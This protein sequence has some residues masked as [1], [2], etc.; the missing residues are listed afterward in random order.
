M[1]KDTAF[2]A[3][4]A[5]LAAADLRKATAQIQRVVSKRVTIPVLGFVKVEMGPIGIRLTATDT[6]MWIEVSIDALTSMP[7][8]TRMISAERLAAF[9]RIATG[10]VTISFDGEM[11][12]LSDDATTIKLR[13]RI[14][15]EDFPLMS[16]G[17]RDVELAKETVMSAE[18][19]ARL[20]DLSCGYASNEETRYYL[21]G[22]HLCT[23]PEGETLR[24]VAT[25]GH[26]LACIDSDVTSPGKDLNVIV[27]TRAINTMRRAL[28][29]EG[30]NAPISLWFDSH[31]V[32]FECGGTAI[33][34]RLVD[35]TY[36]AY[37]RV[38]PRDAAKARLHLDATTVRKLSALAPKDQ[39]FGPAVRLDVWGHTAQIVTRDTEVS[40]P[41]TGALLDS[42]PFVFGL[43]VRLL[44][45][46]ARTTRS[47]TL[48][49][50]SPSN[51]VVVRSDDPDAMWVIMPMRLE[52]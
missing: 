25:D 24:A 42:E 5:T 3:P 35:G 4:T 6:D 13:D 29:P 17:M 37:T 41:I 18:Q 26:K 43:N 27:P 21:C 46:Q 19:F 49:A 33:S 38:L 31:H 51:P 1:P 20:I 9:A 34:A 16:R 40:L 11:T 8:Q 36:P 52:P 10:T 15:V 14:P 45:A 30:S 2:A 39:M 7:L 48:F 28:G 32:R 23:R 22:V 50:S 44:S 12:T 47:F